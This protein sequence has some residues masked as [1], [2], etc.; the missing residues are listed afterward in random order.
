[1][2]LTAYF[3]TQAGADIVVKGVRCEARLLGEM[4][5]KGKRGENDDSS[6]GF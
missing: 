6:S 3:S 1:M 5:F 2:S 4:L